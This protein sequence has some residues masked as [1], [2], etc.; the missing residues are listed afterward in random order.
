[1]ERVNGFVAKSDNKENI[2][3]LEIEGKQRG[4]ISILKVN[5]DVAQLG[6]LLVEPDLRGLGYG[7]RLVQRAI[8][9]CKEKGYQ[10]IILWTNS[11]LK[12]ARCIYKRMGFELKLTRV[13]TLSNR[14][15]QEE[16]W[17]LSIS[18]VV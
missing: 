10:K 14:E 6:L 12:S 1:M 5:D 7:E 11:E 3:V 13:Q 15:V 4:S 2:S 8:D 9:F 18:E 17:E 16:L